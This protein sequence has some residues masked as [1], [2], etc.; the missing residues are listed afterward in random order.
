MATRIST[1]PPY[2]G[3]FNPNNRGADP[4]VTIYCDDQFWVDGGAYLKYPTLR[5]RIPNTGKRPCEDEGMQAYTIRT[6]PANLP[7]AIVMCYSNTEAPI[8]RW[9]NGLAT[10]G[11]NWRTQNW[12]YWDFHHFSQYTSFQ[13]LHEFTHSITLPAGFSPTFISTSLPQGHGGEVYSIAEIASLPDEIRPYNAQG[14]AFLG[15]AMWLAH[16][17]MFSLGQGQSTGCW[18]GAPYPYTS[19]PSTLLHFF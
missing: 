15:A 5:V 14:Y 4:T 2:S 13:L 12:N 10:I 17:T 16:N 9:A 3:I 8:R 18:M 11:Q 7:N 19:R 6:T 1:L